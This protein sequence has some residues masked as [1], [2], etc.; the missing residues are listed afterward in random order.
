VGQRRKRWIPSPEQGAPAP[1]PWSLGQT[2]TESVFVEPYPDAELADVSGRADPEARYDLLE[3]VE[4]AFVAALQALPA[5]QRAVVVLRDVLALPAAEVAETLDTT[6]ASVNSALQRARQTL[7]GR[8]GGPTQQATRR[9]L[10][11]DGEQRLLTSFIHAW[12]HHDVDGLVGLL[13]EDVRLTMPPMPAWFDGRDAV[14]RFYAE[15]AFTDRWRFVPTTA[16]GQLAVV[17]YLADQAGVFRFQ[18][19]DV[20]TLRGTEI[21]GIDAFHDPTVHPDFALAPVAPD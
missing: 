16:S 4:L 7:G 20:L 10:G 9:A 2:V 15:R 21:V 5:T 3:S 19:L 1:D 11:D 6:V 8:L 12:E 14:A 17:G 18:N 13:A